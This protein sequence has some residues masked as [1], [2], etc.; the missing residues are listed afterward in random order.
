[1]SHE[2]REPPP[3]HPALGQLAIYE[4]LTRLEERTL[5]NTTVNQDQEKRL[6]AVERVGL[7]LM[8]YAA[9]GGFAAGLVARLLGI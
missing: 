1:M 7:R 5:S 2:N 3:Q 4:R 8:A 9:A 6:R